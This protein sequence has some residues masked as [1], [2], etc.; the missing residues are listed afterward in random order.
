M[1]SLDL[2][3]FKT[4]KLRVAE[5]AYLCGVSR[6]AAHTWLRKEKPAQPHHLIRQ[7]VGTIVSAVFR[8]VEAG[9]LPLV[10]PDAKTVRTP[11][12]YLVRPGLLNIVK[13]HVM[14]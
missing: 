8:A 10:D 14:R 12:G 3:P 5:V 9:T 6:V 13:N 2:T 4:A 7:R 1:E 11:D